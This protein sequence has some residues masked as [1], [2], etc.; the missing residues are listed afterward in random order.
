MNGSRGASVFGDDLLEKWVAHCSILGCH[1]LRFRYLSSDPDKTKLTYLHCA[2]GIRVHSAAPLL[3][4]MGFERVVP[5]QEG[6][7][8]LASLGFPLKPTA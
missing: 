3:E 7:G 4:G 5:L 2:A 6:F 8:A 1:L